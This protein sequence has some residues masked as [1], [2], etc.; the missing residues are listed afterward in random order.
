MDARQAKDYG[1]RLLGVALLCA[2][3]P[4]RAAQFTAAASSGNAATAA[5]SAN[6]I[7]DSSFFVR[8]HYL[9]FLARVPDAPGSAFW[10]GDI[11]QCLTD[12]ACR[13]AHRVNVSA[14]FFLS[15]E[16]QETGYLVYRLHQAAFDTG[17]ALKLGRFLPDMRELSRGVIVGQAGW[18]E[19]LEQNKR[20]FVG[21]FV[22]RQEFADAFPAALTAAQ[23]VEALDSHTLDPQNRS[24]GGA[25]TQGERDALAADLAAGRRTRAEVL[26]AVAENAEF[27]R[28]QSNKAFV[29][30]QYFGYLRR[31]PN[32]PPDAD[33]NGYNFWLAKL[34]QFGGDFVAAEM[35]KA[36]LSSDEYKARFGAPPPL[37]A[38]RWRQDLQVL[39][40]QLP[41][42]HK[43]A[44]FHVS[45][46]EFEQAVAD[47]DRDIP[48]LQDHEIVVRLM[49]IVALVGDSHTSLYTGSSPEQFKTYPLKLYQFG[50]GLYATAAAAP[51]GD[52]LGA[53]LARIGET[54]AQQAYASSGD[55][56]PHENGQWLKALVPALLASPEALH[57]QHFLP[58]LY[59][60]HFVFQDA[61]GRE[62]AVDMAPVS[63]R[64]NVDWVALPD[65]VQTPAPSYRKHPELNYWFEYLP[66]SQTLFFQYNKCQN[67]P[68]MPFTQFMQTMFASAASQ[69]VARVVVDLRNNTGG[70]SSVLQPFIVALKS[71]PAFNQRGKIYVVTGRL[72]FSS[73]MLNAIT[74]RQQTNSI[75]VGEPTG[76]KPNSYGE[77][78]SFLLPNSGFS[79]FYSTKFFTTVAGDP[80]SLAPDV[81][82]DLQSDDYFSGRD[83]VLQAILSAQN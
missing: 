73:G 22:A 66:D 57:A 10:Q 51:Y 46:A 12:A 1:A 42:L 20:A 60:G 5:S 74:L 28:R 55:L 39:A 50:D 9:D 64:E 2:C 32:D 36:F 16:F 27:R 71:D 77:V 13:E 35:V 24:A 43:N 83:P 21:R 38:E 15:I 8:Q 14:A 19:Q 45:P 17:E 69:Q 79:V 53:R 40:T 26:R 61:S 7:D 41:L 78:R 72:T 4:S 11:E 65:P 54:D 47:L 29:L 49:R 59:T 37:G 48:S 62:F 70:D 67:A 75:L 63:A 33:F 68:G 76:G 18:Q 34:N 31:N 6:P 44:F 25:L 52:V 58:D 56:V 80:S 23:F 81:F 30:M 82:V 3:L